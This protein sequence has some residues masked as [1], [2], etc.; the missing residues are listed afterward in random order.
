MELI[1]LEIFPQALE[2]RMP[3]LAFRGLC[4]LLD[5]GQQLRST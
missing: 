2:E 3:Y 1:L 5:F 4:A